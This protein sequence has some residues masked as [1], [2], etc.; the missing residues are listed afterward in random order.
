M[1]LLP[2]L[3]LGL[4]PASPALQTLVAAAPTLKGTDGFATPFHEA[5][6]GEIVFVSKSMGASEVNDAAALTQL[7]FGE[8]LY[9][10]AFFADST[11]N[12]LYKTGELDEVED[13]VLGRNGRWKMDFYVDDVLL[14]TALM[15]ADYLREGEAHAWTTARGAL[16][17]A[18]NDRNKF[19]AGRQQ[20]D[21]CLPKLDAGLSVGTHALRL[22]I[23]AYT[24]TP[25]EVTS[26]VMA[27]GSVNLK[28][29]APL[30]DPKDTER[31][32]PARASKDAA[33][34]KAMMAEF[35]KKGWEEQ[36]QQLRIVS[37][38]WAVERHSI[39]NEALSRS[40]DAVVGMTQGPTCSYTTFSFTQDA[41]GSGYGP[42]YLDGIGS[43]KEVPCSCLN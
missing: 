14:C 21:Q 8:P 6:A 35:E 17:L 13:W 39:T 32:L 43:K 37:K 26:A 30:Y 5:H 1:S 15:P 27:S 33:L 20:F 25:R 34:E 10:R 11:T 24:D 19:V 38:E 4:L 16:R 41:K 22:D 42:V 29:D 12:M 36:P 3:L 28:I 23:S 40:K 31:C 9:F 18:S 7:T 2:V